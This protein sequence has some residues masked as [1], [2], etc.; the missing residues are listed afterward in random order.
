MKECR[1]V[2]RVLSDEQTEAKTCGAVQYTSDLYAP[3]MLFLVCKG[4]EIA[5]GRILSID[6]SEAE[7]VPGV[8]KIYTFL[9]TPDKLYDRG[10]VSQSEDVPNQERLFARHIRYYGER[11]AAVA[12]STQEAALKA[13]RLIRVEYEALP[14]VFTIE[15]AL[16]EDAF[17]IHEEGN[18]KELSHFSLGKLKEEKNDRVFGTR[19]RCGRI[20]HLSMETTAVRARYE[21]GTKKLSI[22]TGGQTV[23]GIRSTVA[24]FLEMPYS[25][26]RVVKMPMGGS[27]GCKQETILEVL[28]AYAAKDLNADVRWVLSREEQIVSSMQKHSY[29]AEIES[30][31]TERGILDGLLLDLTLDAGAYVTVSGTYVR[32]IGAKLGKTYRINQIEYRGRYVCTNTPICGSFRSW[33]TVELCTA[34]EMHMNHVARELSLDPVELRLRNVHESGD[35]DPV[36]RISVEN[37]RFKD[38]LIKGRDQFAWEEEKRLCEQKNE[39]K[40]RYRYGVG[41]AVCS[42]TSSFYIKQVDVATAS[43]RLQDDGSLIINVPVH[44]HGCGTVLALK[45]IAAEVLQLPPERIELP[46]ADSEK[47]GYDYGCYASRSVYSLGN[48]VK[49]CAEG[50]L[51]LLKE[52]ASCKLDCVLSAVRYKKGV[53]FAENRPRKTLSLHE[54]WCY[55]LEKRGRDLAFTCTVNASANPGTAAAHFVRVRVDT[56]TGHVKVEKYLAVHDVGRAVNPDFCRGQIGSGIQ[57]GIGIALT[58]ELKVDPATGRSLITNFKNYQVANAA[59]LPEYETLLLEEG[60]PSGPFGAKGIGEVVVGPAPA[61]LS[62]AVSFALGMEILDRKSV[63]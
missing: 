3:G 33:G 52:T 30:R 53:F 19:M 7:K 18:K 26:V 55:S 54:L 27:F 58:E 48:A 50:L 11:V 39:E 29:V 16:L 15:E 45:K 10:R 63:V 20:T 57:Q 43:M 35:I 56:F 60:E 37:V 25:K 24:D 8:R 59:D 32:A 62:E 23:F 17:P 6:L 34:L 1:Y 61:A 47:N 42:H 12:A 49:S 44:D 13:C 14:A 40:G 21:K 31:F 22:F 46:E 38:A 28:A 41:M 36:T 9:N 4:S 2:G 51:A 5:H